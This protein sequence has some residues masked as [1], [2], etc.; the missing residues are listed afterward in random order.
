MQDFTDKLFFHGISS[1]FEDMIP[2]LGTIG[3]L[4]N[5]LNGFSFGTTADGEPGYRKPGADAVIPFKGT[6]KSLDLSVGYGN[7]LASDYRTSSFNLKSKIDKYQKL[8]LWDNLFVKINSVYLAANGGMA[9]GYYNF[10][11]SYNP[12]TGV[13]TVKGSTTYFCCTSITVYYF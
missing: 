1:V 5:N 9:S 8:K 13:L 10:A 2:D 12:D 6:P 7:G 11:I 3:E 4:S